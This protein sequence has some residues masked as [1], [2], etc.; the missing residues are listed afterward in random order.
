M[1]IKIDKI[2]SAGLYTV[3]GEKIMDL[4]SAGDI[5]TFSTDESIVDENVTKMILG[6]NL[7]FECKFSYMSRRILN[8]ISYNWRAKGPVR[9]RLIRRI[10]NVYRV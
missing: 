7:S 6:D 5:E 3:D 8:M 1:P 9:K 2:L 10:L 4:S